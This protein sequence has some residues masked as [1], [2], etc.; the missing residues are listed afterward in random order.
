M[1]TGVHSTGLFVKQAL[2]HARVLTTLLE[3]N[4]ESAV[5][6]GLMDTCIVGT[7]MMANSASL[8]SLG[9]WK[10]LLES[11]ELLLIRYRNDG[12]V[13]DE[14]IAQITSELIEKE[15]SFSG[16]GEGGAWDP[17]SVASPEELH[18]LRAEVAILL[19]MEE[20][21]E[22]VPEHTSEHTSQALS[23]SSPCEETAAN[24]AGEADQAP[25]ES[26]SLRKPEFLGGMIAQL[27]AAIGR[28]LREW[29][30]WK[31]RTVDASG[32]DLTTIRQ[33]SHLINFYALSLVD[34]AEM[35][36]ETFDGRTMSTLEPLK[37]VLD[38]YAA[39]L[40]ERDGCR[41]DIGFLGEDMS[42]DVSLLF[43]LSKILKC[44]LSDISRRST[45]RYLR[46]EIEV[47]ERNGSLRWCVR[48]N[49]NNF[50]TDSRLDRDDYLAF[51]PG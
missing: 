42:I 45:E 46:I 11:Y 14:R 13:W 8:L 36:T 39:A 16:S 51:Y 3:T 41:V 17:G 4:S 33:E 21:E 19:T 43:D 44:M 23:D 31:N 22:A 28:L 50:I 20:Q 49:G 47:E 5:D 9:D 7:R 26:R 27:D 15:E 34:I 2:N 10:E 35:N 12:L 37:H 25:A 29:N 6:A 30:G 18:A 38:V 24:P 1:K 40:S 48:D 32:F